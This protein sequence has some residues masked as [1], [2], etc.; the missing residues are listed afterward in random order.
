MNRSTSD[1]NQTWILWELPLIRLKVR[2]IVRSG[3]RLLADISTVWE[4]NKM[5][6]PNYWPSSFD[7]KSEAAP[8]YAE[9]LSLGRRLIRLFALALN[10]PEQYF[11]NMF[12][13][14]GAMLRLIHYPP[15]EPDDPTT[16]GIGAHQD[17]ECFTILC[18]GDED[19]L[20]ICN[21]EGE[22]IEAPA[23][24]DTFVVNVGDMMSRWS[25]DEFT[26]TLHRVINK[27]GRERYSIPFFFGPSYETMIEPLTFSAS[28]ADQGKP[29]YQPVQAGE[30][31][32][33]RLA[34]QKLDGSY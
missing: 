31:V 20:Q 19:G 14:P 26:S 29:H 2:L 34:K 13:T 22:W 28:G 12:R 33:Q 1:T 9:A 18:Q 11:D 6:G 25:N 21:S 8:Y 7:L 15:Q 16:L 23:I 10:A 5:Q 4:E 27:S 30:Y 17:I 24:K 32:W 3:S